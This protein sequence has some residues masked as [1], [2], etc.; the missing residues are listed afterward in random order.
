M[1][2]NNEICTLC[3]D[4]TLIFK[5]QSK[6][7]PVYPGLTLHI[8]PYGPHSSLTPLQA[9][10]AT[11]QQPHY[12][13]QVCV[14][15]GGLGGWGRTLPHPRTGKSTGGNRPPC[16]PKEKSTP[17]TKPRESL[18]S[19]QFCLFIS[20]FLLENKRG[21]ISPTSARRGSQCILLA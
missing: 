15:R 21:G 10:A 9:V 19:M 11:L 1:R 18:P 14:T 20:E 2:L 12:L 6:S 4:M 17:I 3:L 8:C 13:Q 5:L 16:H 7:A